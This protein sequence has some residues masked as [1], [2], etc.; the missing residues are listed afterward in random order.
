MTESVEQ[1]AAGVAPAEKKRRWLWALVV[2]GGVIAAYVGWNM[3]DSYVLLGPTT[4]TV[5]P[6]TTYLTGPLNADG[7]VNYTQALNDRYSEGVTPDNNAVTLLAQAFDV[8][9]FIPEGSTRAEILRQLGLTEGDLA[10]GKKFVSWRDYL[11]ALGPEGEDIDPDYYLIAELGRRPWAAQD[12]PEMAAWLADNAEPL[13]IIT[14]AARRPKHYFPI[15]SPEDPPCLLTVLLPESISYRGAS[16]ALAARAMLHLSDGNITE[17]RADVATIYRLARMSH[18]YLIWHLIN[19]AIIDV[20]RDAEQAIIMS[21]ISSDDFR[22]M[23]ADCRAR[24]PLPAFADVL[25]NE[26]MVP[27]DVT[28]SLYRADNLTDLGLDSS[29]P[30]PWDQSVIDWDTLLSRATAYYTRLIQ[31]ARLPYPER[32]VQEALIYEEFER[33][34]AE[35]V[36]YPLIRAILHRATW[37]KRAARKLLTD[38]LS[39]V[40]LSIFMPELSRAH[41]MHDKTQT[42]SDLML[43][44]LA[45]NVYKADHGDWPEQLTDL[46]PEYL[47]AIPNDRFAAQPLMYVRTDDGVRIYSLGPNMTDDGGLNADELADD[48]DITDYPEDAD[49]LVIELR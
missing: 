30:M 3:F 42:R 41:T 25:E 2:F 12:H 37:N 23:L 20:A 24:P 10:G 18:P 31:A 5:S 4:I 22:A 7:T 28:T 9:D 47:D 40:L 35:E 13:A 43:L 16:R 6:E 26:F 36:K 46:A 8:D 38:V 32:C 19:I 33:Y 29:D 44:A 39:R 49:D 1:A 45:A 27:L 14:Q 15:V 48:A 21:G 11:E 34:L 17:A